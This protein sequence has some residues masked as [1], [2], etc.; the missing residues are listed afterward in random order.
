MQCYIPAGCRLQWP[1]G[2]SLSNLGFSVAAKPMPSPKG[3]FTCCSL[4]NI[5]KL[6]QPKLYTVRGQSLIQLTVN[7][8]LR[9]TMSW[10][11]YW[12]SMFMEPCKDCEFFSGRCGSLIVHVCWRHSLPIQW[13]L[14]SSANRASN[15]HFHSPTGMVRCMWQGEVSLW[16][17]FP[18]IGL[19]VKWSIRSRRVAKLS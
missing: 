16:Y 2:I 11:N 4:Q 8:G 18:E 10:H 3:C 5:T 13:E 1:H 9:Q 12:T 14:I 17:G 15:F 6:K 19:C 7:F